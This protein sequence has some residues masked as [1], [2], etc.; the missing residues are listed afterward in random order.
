VDVIGQVTLLGIAELTEVQP[1]TNRVQTGERWLQI[2]LLG[3]VNRATGNFQ[4]GVGSYP[5]LDDPVHFATSD[6]LESVYPKQDENHIRIGQLSAAEEVSVCLDAGALVMRHTALV[7]STGSGKTSTVARIIQEFSSGNWP[8]ANIVVIDPHGEYSSALGENASV[9]SVIGDTTNLQVPFWA[10]SASDI[11][12]VFAN[13]VGSPT[14]QSRFETL[15]TEGR[16]I[17][18]EKSNWFTIDPAAVTADTPIPF[19]IH[20]VWYQLDYENKQT[21]ALSHD[22]CVEERGDAQTLKPPR[23]TPHAMGNT[24]PNKGPYHGSHGTFPELL[25]IGLM[26]PSLKFFL[27]PKAE[28]E[29]VDPLV[30]EM[31]SWLGGVKPVSVLDFSG[32]P[33]RASELA[34]GV[35]LNLIFETAVRAPKDTDS[36]GRARPVL[37]VLEEAHRYLGE[38]SAKLPRD[39]VNR[40][41]R[42]GRKYG[43]GLFLVTQRPSELPDTAL[44]Q[45]GTLIALR[46]TNSS[47]QSRIGSALPDSV[48]GLSAILPSLRTGEAIITGESLVIPSR[49]LIDLPKPAPMSNDPTLKSWR[50]DATEPVVEPAINAWR[51]TYS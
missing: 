28:P 8:S 16:R 27:A 37:I 50:L 35:V 40:I 15:V 25:R 45:C 11:A 38:G 1:P 24:P 19:D 26:D 22:H 4:R 51:T 12:K 7:G 14:A 17:F 20:E 36:I 47:D 49:A 5:G 41:A 39:A 23:F 6:D 21:E 2:Q 9:Q 42:E 29:G 18:A 48:A 3:E 32:A 43:V 31:I 30:S 44:S 46:L 13:T 10:L 33:F 34:I